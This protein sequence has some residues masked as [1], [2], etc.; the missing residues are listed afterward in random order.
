MEIVPI[1]RVFKVI[2]SCTNVKQLK[3][4]EKLAHYYTE[5]IKRKGVI[6]PTLVKET[7]HIRINEKREE[8]NLSHKFDGKI[9]R[10]KIKMK[11]L[12]TE[13]AENFS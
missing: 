10:R 13:L 11:E 7:L 9:R 6:N 2:D 8:L 5:M 4:C 12:E 1:K 3:T